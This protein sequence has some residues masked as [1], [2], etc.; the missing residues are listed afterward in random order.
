MP[1]G[2]L[3]SYRRSEAEL[4]QISGGRVPYGCS[5]KQSQAPSSL[6]KKGDWTFPALRFAM[7]FW[8]AAEVQSPFFNRL[9]ELRF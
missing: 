3:P 8:G 9:L 4:A 5:N 7:F 1:T 2:N 6:L